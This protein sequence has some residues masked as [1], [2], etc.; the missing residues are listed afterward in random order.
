MQELKAEQEKYLKRAKS[1]I[2]EQNL[3][4][5]GSV[6]I[7]KAIHNEEDYARI[8]ELYDEVLGLADEKVGAFG[9]CIQNLCF[10]A[11][12]PVYPP[13]RWLSLINHMTTLHMHSRNSMTILSNKWLSYANVANC[14]PIWLYVYHPRIAILHT[15]IFYPFC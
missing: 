7:H 5:D 14:R 2:T 13:R 3:P 1:I 4:R 10:I 11:F 12:L 6:D 8:K 9:R 15:T